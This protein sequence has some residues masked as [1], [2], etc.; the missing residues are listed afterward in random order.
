MQHGPAMYNPNLAG[1]Q[2]TTLKTPIEQAHD[3]LS[4]TREVCARIV[5]LVNILCGP[6]PENGEKYPG[7]NASGIFPQLTED[8][9]ET[10]QRL[11]AARE[12]L[13]RL[14]HAIP[15]PSGTATP[16]KYAC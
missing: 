6:T 14:E 4:D 1:G 9:G 2:P 15:Q 10:N 16:A 5:A 8:C 7:Q 13:A 11:S 3:T 12:A